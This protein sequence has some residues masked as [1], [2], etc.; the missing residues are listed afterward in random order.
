[1]KSNDSVRVK[2]I[3]RLV[4]RRQGELVEDYE[5]RNLV[6]DVARVALA[7]LVSG[8][9]AAAPINRIGFGTSNAAPDPADTALTNQLL[10]AVDGHTFPASGEVQFTWS[11]GTSEGNGMSIAEFGLICTDG[12]LFARKN[13]ATAI[14]KDSD[15]TLSGTWTIQF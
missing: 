2:G 3:F 5:D 9:A 4:V 10:K 11:L 14:A 7:R 1:M 12:S 15:I 8:D 13:R 6:V